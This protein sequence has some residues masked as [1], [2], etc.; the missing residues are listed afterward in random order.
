MQTA[1]AVR[2]GDVTD[3]TGIT[4]TLSG[5][6]IDSLVDTTGIEA[7]Q[8]SLDD[9]AAGKGMAVTDFGPWG[10]PRTAGCRRARP[11]RP[12]PATLG[13]GSAA[14]GGGA[15]GG[16]GGGPP[17][18]VGGD[19]TASVGDTYVLID[20]DGDEV[21]VPVVA[22]LQVKLDTLFISNLVNEELFADPGRR[23]AGR[24]DVHPR[25]PGPGR[26]GGHPARDTS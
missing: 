5:A 10:V 2:T 12:S 16:G 7:A 9:V 14:P 11:N 15:P 4:A 13:T 3:A 21:V 23:P 24:P 1:A 22:A 19:G 25:R 18:V 6:D 17:A 20:P 8:G 26:P